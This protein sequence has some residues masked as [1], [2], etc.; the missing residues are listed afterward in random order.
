MQKVCK[1][2]GALTVLQNLDIDIE[3]SEKVAL[4][5]PSGSGKST[6][7]RILMTLESIDSG[8]VVIDGES[9]YDIHEDSTGSSV[10]KQQVS[11]IRAKVGMV[12]QSFNLF[13]HMSVLRNITEA[14]IHVLK[15]SREEAEQQ[16]VEFLDLVGLQDKINAYPAQLSG[17]QKQR[18]AIARALAMQPKIMLF[19]EITSALD[20]E[21][22]AE[23][24]LVLKNLARKTDRTMLMV[25]HQMHFAQ[26]FADRIIFMEQGK[27]VEQGSPEKIFN[28][29]Q[30]ERTRSFLKTVLEAT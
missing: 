26:E 27:I 4:I 9:L 10:S 8:R 5:G 30:K 2:Y 20:P 17:G 1:R 14:P 24:L 13:P 15:L 22:A 6:I 25:T 19:D 3:S 29:P 12:F 28:H 21:L 18:V 7:L 11:R 16:A 23:V